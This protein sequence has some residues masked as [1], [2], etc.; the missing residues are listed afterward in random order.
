MASESTNNDA[1]IANNNQPT[2]VRD[3]LFLDF[4]P[5]RFG[6]LQFLGV[7]I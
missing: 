6:L 7:L 5:I 1:P 3:G 4:P 2:A